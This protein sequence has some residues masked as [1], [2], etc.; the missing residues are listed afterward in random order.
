[1]SFARTVKRKNYKKNLEN[2]VVQMYKKEKSVDKERLDIAKYL[3]GIVHQLGGEV[4][5]PVD[6]MENI[7]SKT[8]KSHVDE[9]TNEYVFY[10]EDTPETT[11]TYTNNNEGE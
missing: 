6:F 4:R 2:A 5:L 8:I 9:K 1:M 11:V 3:G 10:L 7:Q